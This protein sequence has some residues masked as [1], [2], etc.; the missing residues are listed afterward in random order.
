MKMQLQNHAP[1]D[2]APEKP[3]PALRAG[4]A[5]IRRFNRARIP[6]V[7]ENRRTLY[8]D[9]KEYFEELESGEI[10]ELPEDVWRS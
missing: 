6:A 7:K 2:F 8:R 3:G 5:Q 9:V 4:C 10:R 1:H